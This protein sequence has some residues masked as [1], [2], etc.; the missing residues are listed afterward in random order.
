MRLRSG[1]RLLFLPEVRPPPAPKLRGL[2]VPLRAR[3]RL[4]PQVR[5]PSRRATGGG[6]AAN[7]A[8]GGRPHVRPRVRVGGRPP[9]GDRPVRRC[10]RLHLARRAAGPGGRARVPER[11]VQDARG[12]HRGVRR[13]RG[14]VRRRRRHGGVRRPGRPRGR[15]RAR[16]PYRAH[17]AEARRADQRALGDVLRGSGQ[18]PPRDQHGSRGRGPARRRGRRGVRRHRRHG[19]HRRPPSRRVRGRPD[20]RE[21]RDPSTHRPRFRVRAVAADI[22]QGQGGAGGALARAGPARRV[23]LWPGWRWARTH[24]TSRRPAGRARADAGGLRTRG[25][26]TRPGRE[27][28]RRGRHRQVAPRRR[29]V[30]HPRCAR[31]ARGLQRA[32]EHLQLVRR[33]GVR[34]AARVPARRLPAR[35]RGLARGGG[36]QARRRPPRARLRQGRGRAHCASPGPRARH[37]VERDTPAPRA[38]AAPTPDLS[39]HAARAGAPAPAG[40]HDPRCREPALG[41]HG[42][43]RAPPL[44]RRSAQRPA[45]HAPGHLPPRDGRA[46]PAHDARG[47]H[48]HPS[49]AARRRR[50]RRAAPR[51]SGIP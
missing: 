40:A 3:L 50:Q 42:L 27:P 9:A 18:A 4:L 49:D 10:L 8:P 46:V 7:V 30:R 14:E 16:A 15:S 22:P 41:G 47:P 6:T 17:G 32:A 43:D 33:T 37:R 51:P 2:R 25:Q 34:G 20:P 26:W 45:A 36:R 13:L 5:C 12:G 29:A 35:P 44:R 11:P 21:R 39:G 1:G 28:R 31:P 19:E 23:P 48:Q 38:R 24:R